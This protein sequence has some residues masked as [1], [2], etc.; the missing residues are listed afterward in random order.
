MAKLLER[1]EYEK[2]SDLIKTLVPINELTPKLQNEVISMASIHA[3][4]KK[5]LYLNRAMLMV[6][7]ITSSMDR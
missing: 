1:G 3:F 6:M 7:P 5:N 2:Y 4:K